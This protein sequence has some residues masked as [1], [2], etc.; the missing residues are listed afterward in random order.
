MA[1]NENIPQQTDKLK[2]SQPQLLENFLQIGLVWTVDHE[3]FDET[4]EGKH[5]KATL[6]EQLVDPVV[7]NTQVCLYAKTSDITNNLELFK[8]SSFNNGNTLN[9][10][11]MTGKDAA[12]EGW[13]YTPSGLVMKWGKVSVTGAQTVNFPVD[14]AIPRFVTNLM[15]MLNIVDN[16]G[17]DPDLFVYLLTYNR[18]AFTAFV[19][20]RTNIITTPATSDVYYLAL[21]TGV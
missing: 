20:N 4:N 12:E 2:I 16:S 21:G 3:D 14:A 1:Y 17:V 13:S 18:D 8:V 10:F 9:E 19:I 15:V 5:A 11:A 6:P 7:Q